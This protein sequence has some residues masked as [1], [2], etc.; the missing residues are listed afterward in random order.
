[1]YEWTNGAWKTNYPYNGGTDLYVDNQAINIYSKFEKYSDYGLYTVPD[2]S[3]N[4]NGGNRIPFRLWTHWSS[5]IN[6]T[7]E[8][9]WIDIPVIKADVAL[10]DIRLID[11]NGY[12]ITGNDIYANQVVTPQYVITSY[13]IHYTKLYDS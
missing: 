3:A 2:N 5:D 12:Y 10:V 13:S 1:M 8:S 6:N 4:T 7:T 11:K 9:T